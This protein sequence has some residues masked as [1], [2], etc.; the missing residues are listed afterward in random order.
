MLTFRS[1]PLQPHFQFL[2][3][4]RYQFRGPLWKGSDSKEGELPGIDHC[5]PTATQ[6]THATTQT[7]CAGEDEW[8]SP[9]T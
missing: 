2:S 4:F 3:V 6:L 9:D 5:W 8:G 7:H 1:T